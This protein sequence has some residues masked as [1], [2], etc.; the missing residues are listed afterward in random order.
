MCKTK[1]VTTQT[2][3]KVVEK[4]PHCQYRVKIDSSNQVTLRNRGFLRKIAPVCFDERTTDILFDSHFLEFLTFTL[5]QMS[6]QFLHQKLS[7]QN[8][9]YQLV[10]SWMH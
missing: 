1:M 5:V 9:R 7:S 8:Q 4:L 10:P 6:I 2:T 3:G